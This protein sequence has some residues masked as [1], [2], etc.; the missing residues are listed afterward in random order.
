MSQVHTPEVFTAGEV[1]RAAGVPAEAV[2]TLL[3]RGELSFIGGTRYISIPNAP[4][5]ARRLREVGLAL[6]A[7]PARR[8]FAKDGA[9]RSTRKPVF[10][11]LLA[12]GTLMLIAVG[13]SMGRTETAPLDE[14]IHEESH[15]VFLLSPGPG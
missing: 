10:A 13:L 9:P 6:H 12:H 15:L 8:L 14:S 5:V 2:R 3:G 11:A 7:E 4:R 1:A